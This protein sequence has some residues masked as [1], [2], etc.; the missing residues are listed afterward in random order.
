M[1]IGIGFF[2]P[3]I[4]LGE[5]G[6]LVSKS[7]LVYDLGV[8]IPLSNLISIV[9]NVSYSSFTLNNGLD[10]FNTK[11]KVEGT[12]AGSSSKS[13]SGT[14]KKATIV[15]AGITAKMTLNK[16]CPICANPPRG[17]MSPSIEIGVK[18]IT[19]P[20]NVLKIVDDNIKT[21]ADT[22]LTYLQLDGG[23]TTG[24]YV[25]PSLD[26]GYWLTNRIALVGN[27]GYSFGSKLSLD[28]KTWNAVDANKDGL[29]TSQEMLSGNQINTTINNSIN[30]L[31]AGIG[32]KVSLKKTQKLV[33]GQHFK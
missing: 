20:L 28:A 15:S 19:F 32:L 22:K 13:V 33:Q 23:N 2:K 25:M 11:Y 1:H 8:E 3:N 18:K 30:Y 21:N 7:A 26:L 12:T 5:L 14:S 10:I 27:I 17:F 29:F 4:K 31:K 16:V 9:P 24:L 6:S